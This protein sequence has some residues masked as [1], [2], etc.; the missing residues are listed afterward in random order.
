MSNPGAADFQCTSVGTFGA[1]ADRILT[2]VPAGATPGRPEISV[3]PSVTTN[4]AAVTVAV[5]VALARPVPLDA[6]GAEDPPSVQAAR[7]SITHTTTETNPCCRRPRSIFV[8]ASLGCWPKVALEP[9]GAQPQRHRYTSRSVPAWAHLVRVALDGWPVEPTAN[10]RAA[11]AGAGDALAMWREGLALSAIADRLGVSVDC[12]RRWVAVGRIELTPRR[13]TL[14]KIERHYGWSPSISQKY[15]KA[16]IMPPPDSPG[17]ALRPWW[18]EQPDHP[19]RHP[20]R[21]AQR[22]FVGRTRRVH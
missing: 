15:R 1:F 18:W 19:R 7:K 12:L 6:V 14:A 13:W 5:S 9:S 22:D 10:E 4:P 17:S 20:A 3:D 8:P 11:A 16:G 2:A 21:R